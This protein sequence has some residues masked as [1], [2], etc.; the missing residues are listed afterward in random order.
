MIRAVLRIMTRTM[1]AVV[2]T[3]VTAGILPGCHDKGPCSKHG[4][5]AEIEGNH[6]HVLNIPAAAVERGIG[7]TYRIEGAEHEHAVVL[8]FDDFQKLA[9]GERVEARTTSVEAHVH[10]VIVQCKP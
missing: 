4:V 2:F 1:I 5:K 6:H 3:F 10:S 9:K 8:H 7:G